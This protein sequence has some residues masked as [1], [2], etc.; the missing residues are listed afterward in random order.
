MDKLRVEASNPNRSLYDN[1]KAEYSLLRYGVQVQASAS[2][3][4]QT[5]FLI[6]WKKPELNDFAIAEEVT[7]KGRLSYKFASVVSC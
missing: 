1:N 7:L 6:N 3:P 5:V 2:E 4:N